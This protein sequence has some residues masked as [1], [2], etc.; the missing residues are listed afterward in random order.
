MSFSDLSQNGILIGVLGLVAIVAIAIIVN[1]RRRRKEQTIFTLQRRSK[2]LTASEK[3][4]FECLL[5]ALSDEF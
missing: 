5:N 3:T 4:F 1:L 2:L